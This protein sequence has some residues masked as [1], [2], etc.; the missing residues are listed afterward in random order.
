[1]IENQD[2]FEAALER[3]LGHLERPLPGG[4]EDEAF[5]QLMAEIASFDP[6]GGLEA[7]DERAHDLR[8]RAQALSAKATAFLRRHDE[9]ERADRL[10][11]FP[12]DGQG[13]GPTTGV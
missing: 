12:E 9:R 1:M 7:D 11:T 8:A 2:D 4:P 13:I 10:M 5:T 6:P 3:L